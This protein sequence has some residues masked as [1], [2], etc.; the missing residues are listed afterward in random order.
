MGIPL[1][2]KQV[3]KVIGQKIIIPENVEKIAVQSKGL[4][5]MA[6]QVNF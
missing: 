3:F 6:S 2:I 4:A 1:R 5:A